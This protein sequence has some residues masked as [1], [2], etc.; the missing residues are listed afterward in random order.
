[1]KIVV[2]AIFY[3]NKQMLSTSFLRWM[4][5]QNIKMES[6]NELKEIDIKNRTCYYFDHIMTDRD[7]YSGDTLLEE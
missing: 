7:I 3:E 6:E 5:V 1:M 4:S 2:R